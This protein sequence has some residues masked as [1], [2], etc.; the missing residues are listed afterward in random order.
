MALDYLANTG[1]SAAAFRSQTKSLSN[2]ANLAIHQPRS[3]RYERYAY[4]MEEV[5]KRYK[6]LS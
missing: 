1:R 2:T 3:A 4:G 6:A 5:W